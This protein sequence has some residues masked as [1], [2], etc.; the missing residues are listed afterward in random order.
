LLV[1]AA[2]TPF[3]WRWLK[4]SEKGGLGMPGFDQKDLQQTFLSLRD[5]FNAG[6]YEGMRALLHPNLTW[7][8]LH[9]ADSITGADGV[10][11]WL[12]DS[13]RIPNPQFNPDLNQ[14]STSHLR[15]G[16]VQISGPAEWLAEK[17]KPK[18]VESIE[19]NFTFTT[20]RDDRWLL[21]SAFGR[22]MP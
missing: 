13:K 4:G 7:K 18:D 1:L 20:D 11:Q 9:S 16:G 22:V 10:I 2:A 6:D 17:A 8:K 3:I 5:L 21:I 15:D 19:Y 12:K 14:E